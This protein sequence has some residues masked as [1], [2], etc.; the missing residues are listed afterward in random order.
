MSRP[1]KRSLSASKKPPPIAET[2]IAG[3]DFEDPD[4]TEALMETEDAVAN[5]E[6]FDSALRI[7]QDAEQ[8]ERDLTT[9]VTESDE[10]PITIHGVAICDIAEKIDLM[11]KVGPDLEKL[12][13]VEK[14]AIWAKIEQDLGDLGIKLKTQKQLQ[15]A[16]F[17]Y[18]KKN[19]HCVALGMYRA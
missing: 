17:T 9:I 1:R 3:I 10:H 14:N 7:E 18:V 12:S 6:A 13:K 2:Q 16:I 4:N 19:C 11:I 8:I 15:K 5:I